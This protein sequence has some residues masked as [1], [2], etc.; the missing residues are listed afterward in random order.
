MKILVT[1]AN[2]F[3]GRHLCQELL[4]EGNDV[5]AAVR[6]EHTAP[7]LTKEFPFGDLMGSVDWASALE[8]VDTVVHLA[9]RVHVMQ[10]TTADPSAAFRRTNVDGTMK[11]ANAAAAA[12]VR[13]FVYMSSIKVNGEQTSDTPF[14]A[15]SVPNPSDPYGV[16]KWK[17]ESALSELAETGRM[18]VISV[19]TPLVYGPGVGGNMM[20][21]MRLASKG[22]PVPLGDIRN[23][24]TM[25]SVWNLA[26]LLTSCATRSGLTSGLVL[27]GDSHSPSTPELY[28]ELAVAIGSRPRLWNIPVPVLFAIGRLTGKS[29]EVARLCDSLEV[30]TSSSIPGFNWAAPVSF[31]EG[32]Q[33]FGSEWNRAGAL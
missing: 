9:A 4:D 7:E 29:Q 20:R 21:L 26:Q 8:G 30:R 24:R 3:V 15:S 6:R 10:D 14:D 1:G 18:T 16:S 17:A 31:H 28:R 19:R 25:I 11:L 5:V 2:G 23:K 33:R 12:G 32:V 13:R 27:A 22:Y